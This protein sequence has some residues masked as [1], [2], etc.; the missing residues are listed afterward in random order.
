MNDEMR[1][2]GLASAT[3]RLTKHLAVAHAMHARQ[4]G[5][6]PL[7]SGRQI[8]AALAATRGEDRTA[9]ARTHPKTETVLLGAA[10]VIWL[11]G[12]LAHNWSLV[13]SWS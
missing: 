6:S 2:N 10:T 4:H 13:D 8:R 1:L 11:V 5:L 12:A 9:G 3:D 7:G